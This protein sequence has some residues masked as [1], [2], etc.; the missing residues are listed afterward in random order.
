MSALA[1]SRLPKTAKENRTILIENIRINDVII[2]GIGLEPVTVKKVVD[3]Q[4][5]TDVRCL[6]LVNDKNEVYDRRYSAW[7]LVSIR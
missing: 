1:I 6:R 7:M 3:P 5:D 4:D 2:Y